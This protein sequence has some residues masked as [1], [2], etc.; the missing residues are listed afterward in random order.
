MKRLRALILGLACLAATPAAAADKLTVLL[1]WAVNPDHAPLI[2][3]KTQGYFAARGLEVELIAPSD[4]NDPP[5]LV[6]AG[7]ADLAVTYQ[8]QLVLLVDQGLPL[9]RVATLIDT[10]LNCLAVLADGPVKSI[11]DLK[12]RKIGYSVAGF[13]DALLNTMLATAGLTNADVQLVNVNF[14]LATSL[15]AGQVDAVIG[16][17]RNFEIPEMALLGKPARIFPVEDHGVPSYD[18]LIIAAGADK[19]DDPRIARFVAAL[20]DGARYTI[21]HPDEAWAAFIAAYPELNDELNRQAWALT[22]PRFAASPA[23]LDPGRF[24]R[25]ASFL[26]QAGLIAKVSPPQTYAAF[27]K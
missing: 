22:L 23:A 10:P 12:G 17:Y 27:P 15:A 26:H 14:A 5:K 1:D 21:N 9:K 16:A 25:A 6:A 19:A 2:L 3:A 8:P 13:E 11:A 18:E 7:Q 24:T 4:P 20:E